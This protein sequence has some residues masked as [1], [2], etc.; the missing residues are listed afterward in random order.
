MRRLGI[1]S[2]VWTGGQTQDGLEM[3]LRKSAE[4]GYR[5]IEFA[6]LRPEK[7]DLDRL[8][9]LSQA[10]DVE[11]GVTMGLPLDKDV[12]SDEPA[13]VEAGVAM[14]ADAVSAVRDIG[15]NKLGGI[16]YSAHTKYNRQPTKRGWDNSV[17]AI[18]R[19]ADYAEQCSVDLVL[20][21]V[22]R[23]ETNLLNTTAQGLEFI[24]DNRLRSCS[25][26]S[27]YVPHEY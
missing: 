7:F 9:K 19:T 15:G 6:Y 12:S 8:A 20:E 10:L 2:F 23:F 17:A 26:S 11:I 21:V 27:R 16:L 18:A 25:A 3:A 22:N 24:S 14:L 5:T 13:V 1:H 4:H